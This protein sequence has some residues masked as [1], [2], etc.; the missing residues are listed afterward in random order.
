MQPVCEGCPIGGPVCGSSGPLGAKLMIVG[1]A[2]GYQ[3]EKYKS[4]FSGPAG[5]LL[6]QTLREH[7]MEKKDCYVTNV[8]KCHPTKDS[9]DIAPNKDMV[10]KCAPTLAEEIAQVKPKAILALGG[11]AAHALLDTKKNVSDL[12]GLF[13]ISPVH[14]VPVFVTYHPSAI[15]HGQEGLFN[16]IYKTVKRAILF[17]NDQLPMHVN[18]NVVYRFIR[19]DRDAVNILSKWE[20]RA[21]TQR[22][23]LAIDTES[24]GPHDGPRFD[25]DTWDMFQI[26]DGKETY[27]FE[28]QK[29]NKALDLLRSMLTENHIVWIMHNLAHDQKM[30]KRHLG[31][32]ARHFRDTMVLGLGLTERGEEVG[33]K[34]MSREWFNA[35]YYERE[36]EEPCELHGNKFTWKTGPLC[37]CHWLALAKYGCYDSYYT[38]H[39]NDYLPKLVQEEGTLELCRNLLLDAQQ[40]FAEVGIQGSGEVDQEYAQQLEE[41]WL[42]LIREAEQKIQGYAEAQGFPQDPKMVGAQQKAVPCPDCICGDNGILDPWKVPAGMVENVDRKEWRATLKTTDFG[43][44]SCR[45]CMKRRY[46]LVPDTVLNVRSPKQLQHLAFDILKMRPVDRNKR[47]TDKTFLEF[48]KTHPFAQLML[49]LKEKDHLLRSYVYGIMDDVWSDGEI[50]PDFLLFGAVNGRLSIHNPPMQTLPKWGVANKQLAEMTR[51]LFRARPGHLFADIDFKNLE[52]FTAAHLSQDENLYRALT[53]AD[54]HTT[55]AAAIFNKPYDQVTG[56]D[57]FNSK[58]VTFGIAYG[59]QAYSLAQGEL[60]PITGGDER[61]AQKYI[62]RLWGLYPKWK[63]AYDR[64]QWEAVNKGVLTTP[65]GRKRRWL[66]ITKQNLNSIKNQAVNFPPASLASDINLSAMIRL[67]RILPKMGLGRPLFPVHDSLVSEVLE[68]RLQEAIEIITREMTTPPF[69]TNIKFQVDVEI[70]RNLG[71]VMPY[72][73]WLELHP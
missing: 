8:V 16:N 3:D 2:P 67:Q 22:I 30:F 63:E 36:L 14:N 60:K 34:Y 40:M 33:L 52:L 17:V 13:E 28:V 1:E 7:G 18:R 23:R 58:F 5:K 38:W 25:V 10:T 54:Y 29:L 32:Y 39:L 6:E 11:T 44:P 64:W 42:P 20:K 66:L 71:E 19:D 41:Q 73:K 35:A 46:V 65:M 26:S 51:K 69:E 48:N 45:R 47:S 12:A 72:K 56:N 24:H 21:R 49:D 57:R 53:E 9:K 27:A 4:P 61:E 50:H 31:V 70:G 68:A 37:E 59:R 15:L 62:D 55:T 43:D